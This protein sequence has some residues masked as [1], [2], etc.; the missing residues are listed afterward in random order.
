MKDRIDV[1]DLEDKP[2][3]LDLD[4]IN[5]MDILSTAKEREAMTKLFGFHVENI[6]KQY[7]PFFA[8]FCVRGKSFIP[9]ENLDRMSKK[10][11]VASLCHNLY[12]VIY[13]FSHRYH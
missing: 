3:L 1:S 2:A 8:K 12:L 4:T 5:V 9:H 6:L 7:M 11:E 13:I 10:S